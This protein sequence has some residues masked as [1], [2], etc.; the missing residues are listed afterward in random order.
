MF[1]SQISDAE[2]EAKRKAIFL[3]N[4]KNIQEHNEFHNSKRYISIYTMYTK[5]ELEYMFGPPIDHLIYT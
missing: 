3:R 4:A 2:E 1:K 5:D